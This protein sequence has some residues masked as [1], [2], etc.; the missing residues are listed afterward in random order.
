M[1]QMDASTANR[2][3]Q[4]F[5][6]FNRYM[7]W[8]WRLGFRRG[9]N[10][11]PRPGGRVMVVTHTGRKSGARYRTPLNYTIVDDEIY[12]M[13][14]FGHQADWFRNIQSHP[15]V[16]VWLPDSWWAGLA[17]DRSQDQRRLPIL[18]QVLLDTGIVGPLFGMD[19]RKLDDAELDRALGD[20]CLVQIHR[21]QRLSGPGGPGD[22]A[23]VWI[24]VL[25]LLALV[26]FLLRF[27]L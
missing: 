14:G 10:C 13:A 12:C 25:G 2:T 7:V 11:W 20:S 3:R 24:P 5:K 8:F 21:T 22:L 19:A 1:D 27:W 26:Y 23:W 15:Q 4:F 6:N 18:R 17:E 16:E 9:V